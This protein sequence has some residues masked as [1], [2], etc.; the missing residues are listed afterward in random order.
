MI[1]LEW[2]KGMGLN[3]MGMDILCEKKKK[4]YE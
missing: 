2:V 1:E 4:G 3:K